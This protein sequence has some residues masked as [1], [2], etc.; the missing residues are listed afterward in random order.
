[1]NV[2][3]NFSNKQGTYTKGA[4]RTWRNIAEENEMWLE[5]TAGD[6]TKLKMY[7]NCEF[8]PIFQSENE[9]KK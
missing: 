1:M 2:E 3:G 6:R 5:E 7:Y 8:K 9:I 4:M